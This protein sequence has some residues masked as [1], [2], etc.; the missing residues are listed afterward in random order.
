MRRTALI[1]LAQ[2]SKKH[3]V[4]PDGCRTLIRKG[5]RGVAVALYEDGSAHRA[6]IDLSLTKNMT[7]QLAA[8]ALDL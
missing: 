1:A 7:I 6:D 5:K 8:K 2:A 4:T 3:T